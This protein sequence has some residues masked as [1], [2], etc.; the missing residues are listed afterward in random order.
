M[1]INVSWQRILAEGAVIV[2]SILVAFAIDAWW[3]DVQDQRRQA[4]LITALKQDF[5][6]TKGR[7]E[8]SIELAESLVARTDSFQQAVRSEEPASIASLRHDGGGAFSKINFEPALSAYES[9]V[10]TGSLGLIESPG[11]L[12]SITEFN[13][14]RDS[15]ELHDRITADIHFLGPVWE[16]RREIGSLGVLFDDIDAFSG[17]SPLTEAEYR[18]LYSSPLVIAAIEAVATANLNIA[19]DL[20]DMHESAV[21]ILDELEQLE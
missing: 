8:K 9:A 7:L 16:L 15:Y 17:H 21:Q 13:E 3:D 10:A 12:E 1:N 14:A 4:K 19:D 20:R 5:A 11:L 6:T 18:Q 2:V